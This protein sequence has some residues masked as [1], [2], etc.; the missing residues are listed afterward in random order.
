LSGT[1]FPIT[2]DATDGVARN[3]DHLLDEESE[4]IRAAREGDRES[5]ARV[6]D[7]YWERL[8]RWLYHLTRD[9]HTAE[10]IAQ[11]TFLKAF[12]ALRSFRPGSN[13]R[14]WLFRIAHNTFINQQRSRRHQRQPLPEDLPDHRTSPADELLSREEYQRL[15]AA[16]SRLPVEFRSALMLRAEEDLS[17]R[18]IAAILDITEETARWRVFKARQKLMRVLRPEASPEDPESEAS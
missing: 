17:F 11:E 2:Q 10:D 9:L 6:V 12:S 8:Y 16:V 15:L 18:E 4:W 3:T 5:F 13:F 14:A 7:R 1:A